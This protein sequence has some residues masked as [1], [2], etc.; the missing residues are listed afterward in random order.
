MVEDEVSFNAPIPG[1]GLTAELG[2][3]PWQTPP[4]YTTVEDAL[5]YYIPRLESEEVSEQLLDV[6]EMGV[7]VTN[8][9][10]TMQTGGVLQGKHSVDVGMLVVPI[11]MEMIMMLG[12]SA[13]IEYETGLTNPDAGKPRDSQL[14]KY[15]MKY[16]EKLKDTDIEEVKEEPV[17]E[18]EDKPTGL[19]ARRT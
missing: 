1:Q 15:A 7:P 18:E 16:K 9:A 13:D 3:R 8:V 10:D 2:A 11:L 6:L 12:D 4:Q 14:A 19:M 5:D 17:E